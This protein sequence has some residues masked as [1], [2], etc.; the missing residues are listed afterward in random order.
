[1]ILQNGQT[2]G[3]NPFYRMQRDVNPLKDQTMS[4]QCHLCSSSQVTIQCEACK[5]LNFCEECYQ[6]YHRHPKRR[7]H[8]MVLTNGNTPQNR[9]MEFTTTKVGMVNQPQVWQCEFCTY[10]NESD[11]CICEM[12]C[13]T[14]TKQRKL[15]F[16]SVTK[17]TV[18]T[19]NQW[20][21]A[22]IEKISLDDKK[23]TE[24]VRATSIPKGSLSQSTPKLNEVMRQ[25]G[26]GSAT[27]SWKC[28][29]CT[30]INLANHRVCQMCSKT[31]G[32]LQ[33]F[34]GL[35]NAAPM[36][37]SSASIGNSLPRPTRETV[38]SIE[39]HWATPGRRPI[40]EQWK[41]E[42]CGYINSGKAR[43]CNI[44][45]KASSKYLSLPANL[46]ST[47]ASTP[48]K[49]NEKII[50]RIQGEHDITHRDR[51]VLV[52]ELM[53]KGHPE[54]AAVKA[55]RECST[56]TEA[57]NYLKDFSRKDPGLHN[58]D[59]DPPSPEKCQSLPITLN[60]LGWTNTKMEDEISSEDQMKLHSMAPTLSGTSS[61]LDHCKDS[62][63]DTHNKTY[64]E[65][66]KKPQSKN[67][68]KN[69]QQLR[70]E[71]KITN[72]DKHP[73]LPALA[74]EKN[75]IDLVHKL[76][77]NSECI[78][79][80]PEKCL[81]TTSNVLPELHNLVSIPKTKVNGG[82]QSTVAPAGF[83]HKR[84][85]ENKGVIQQ[86]VV[87]VYQTELVNA[88]GCNSDTVEFSV[89]EQHGQRLQGNQSS[90]LPRPTNDRPESEV[91]NDSQTL[92]KRKQT[93]RTDSTT[94]QFKKLNK[95]LETQLRD[96]QP[97]AKINSSI[98]SWTCPSCQS[99]N[100]G[101]EDLCKT[102]ARPKSARIR[103]NV[104]SH[105]CTSEVSNAIETINEAPIHKTNSNTEIQSGQL[106]HSNSKKKKK[107]R[108]RK[109][110]TNKSHDTSYDAQSLESNKSKSSRRFRHNE[111]PTG[112][113]LS[114]ILL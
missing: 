3:M 96:K 101:P 17:P 54:I 59:S 19:S 39:R 61:K 31:T 14:T 92:P 60:G 9:A 11:R 45:K 27:S 69:D 10:E 30:Y 81:S 23:R 67:E 93:K 50:R 12:C 65:I 57:E 100:E 46:A 18:T 107:S 15:G 5:G 49:F 76:N 77:G 42:G 24:R 29:H 56:L 86:H 74:E 109:S 84:T 51:A 78:K 47:T 43:I 22:Q 90:T 99:K 55:S 82:N 1:M 52:I 114:C 63:K 97:M 4:V 103:Q 98:K 71:L 72:D 53:Q 40:S 25:G 111:K 110:V 20:P 36:A 62:T 87:E 113:L 83:T 64:A 79:E 48:M 89:N 2:A 21:T 66:I 80:S 35:V 6:V 75:T 108:R 26:Q 105:L 102:C 88:N 85:K 33:H 16:D 38:L 41:C 28:L 112:G 13:R 37:T 44:C 8:V 104:H 70:D 32:N 34:V 95:S 68:V 73:N 106:Q 7:D 91:R 58:S 94:E